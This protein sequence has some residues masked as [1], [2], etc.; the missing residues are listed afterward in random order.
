MTSEIDSLRCSSSSTLASWSGRD[1][2]ALQHRHRRGVVGQSDYQQRHRA[3][4]QRLGRQSGRLAVVVEGQDLQ[5]GGQV[6]LAD[7]DV[8]RARSA[9][10]GRSSGSRSRRPPTSRSQTSCA[11]PAG[12]ATT[13]IAMF[14]SR[15]HPVQLVDVLDGQA[16]QLAADDRGVGV[17]DG[18][19]PEAAG[20]E[21]GVAGQRPAEVAEAD[22]GDRPVLVQAQGLVDLLGQQRRRRSRRRAPRRSRG[23]TG[24][25][26]AWP[27]SPRPRR[28]A[29]PTTPS[30]CRSRPARPA[31]AGRWPA[32][33]RS[34]RGSSR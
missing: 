19:D 10:S 6:D 11:A 7:V 26:A 28:P 21:A 20:G 14:S 18:R 29:T 24:P 31:R 15:D 25:C 5:L 17:Q 16:A 12:T 27:S 22:Q 9:P 1:A 30:R 8:R 32:G 4:R 23:R 13:A 2:G 33:P 3:H 34:L